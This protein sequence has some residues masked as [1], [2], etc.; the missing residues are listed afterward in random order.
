VSNADIA[1]HQQQ[2]ARIMPVS[3]INIREDVMFSNHKG[4]EKSS[5]RKRNL[6]ALEK[7][8]PALERFLQPNEVVLYIARGRTPLTMLEQL[9]SGWWTYLLASVGVVFTNQRI[10]FFPVK[11]DGTWKE[12][13]RSALWGDVAAVKASGLI[14]RNLAFTF[15]NGQ[16]QTYMGFNPGDAKKIA[17]IAQALIPASAGEMSVTH[18]I[19][20]L[21]PDC[22]GTLTPSVYS[23]RSC[24]LIFKD[25]KSMILRSIF[26]PAGGY[27]YTGHPM[28]AFLPALV[29]VI[30]L[31]NVL[32]FILIRGRDA[33]A[34]ENLWGALIVLFIYW[35]LETAITILHCRRYIREFI[36]LKRAR[37]ETN[38]SFA[39]DGSASI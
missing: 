3:G 20:Q 33:S 1:I 30:V 29:E 35:A 13:V 34:A 36:P 7:L 25:E 10:L 21:C 12:S 2:F 17:L 37:T 9:T 14:T 31:L 8:R 15:R 27:F 24:G 19:V 39:A 11:T 28:I 5:L 23:C 38:R 16:K 6:T 18:G 26:L 32:G 4:Q 22:R